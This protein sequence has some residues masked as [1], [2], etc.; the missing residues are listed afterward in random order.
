MIART[1]VRIRRRD[2]RTFSSGSTCSSRSCVTHSKDILIATNHLQRGHGWQDLPSIATWS[3]QPCTGKWPAC[4]QHRL[5][6]GRQRLPARRTMLENHLHHH[7]SI[8]IYVYF[9]IKY[10]IVWFISIAIPAYAVPKSVR[11]F[12]VGGSVHERAHLS[13]HCTYIY[14]S[15]KKKE[16]SNS[17]RTLT[18]MPIPNMSMQLSAPS[19]NFGNAAGWNAGGAGAAVHTAI[20]LVSAK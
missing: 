18:D 2:R 16:E 8:Y 5:M 15:S 9:I 17:V 1:R 4:C 10:K 7:P 11:S 3:N 20:M 12:C 14:L 6:R 19:S 13:Q